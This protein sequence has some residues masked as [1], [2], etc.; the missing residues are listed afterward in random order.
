MAD[1]CCDQVTFQFQL[2]LVRDRVT[3]EYSE[4]NL[5]SLKQLAADFVCDK[6][7]QNGVKRLEDRILLFKHNYESTNILQVRLMLARKFFLRE[8]FSKINVSAI[9][10]ICYHAIKL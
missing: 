4:L 8:T 6:H 9:G 7:P 10:L 5:K 1:S 2:G 3:V